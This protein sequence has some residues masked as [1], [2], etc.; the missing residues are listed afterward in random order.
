MAIR[1]AIAG[2]I[3]V[4]GVAAALGVA[5]GASQLD[6][7]DGPIA[8]TSATLNDV[9]AAVQ[10]SADPARAWQVASVASIED[11]IV[12]EGPGV[13]HR[14][15]YIWQRSESLCFARS[16]PD[17]FSIQIDGAT[18]YAGGDDPITGIQ[19]LATTPDGTTAHTL[20]IAFE[21]RCTIAW[22]T[23]TSPNCTPP[24]LPSRVI[25]FYRLNGE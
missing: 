12:L 9:L 20:D 1:S 18:V 8:P 6:P 25:V 4:A 14:V 11:A 24:Q 10:S 7:P 22:R 5:G 13:L 16:D 21:Q 3:I 15:V 23:E 19:T 17:E 2:G